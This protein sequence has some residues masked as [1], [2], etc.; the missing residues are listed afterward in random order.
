MLAFA[1]SFASGWTGEKHFATW[2]VMANGIILAMAVVAYYF[3][4]RSLTTLHLKSS[5][6]ANAIGNDKKGV[7]S[8]VM[9]VA[10]IALSF[11]NPWT[12]FALY[13]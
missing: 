8:V 5:T 12:G 3:L 6:R 4:A 10:G 7:V 9:Y 13:A 2:P 11:M 1:G